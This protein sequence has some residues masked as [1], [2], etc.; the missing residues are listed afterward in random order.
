ML[1]TDVTAPAEAVLL[2]LL[3]LCRWLLQA[4]LAQR[5]A[6]QLTA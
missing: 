3:L 4:A 6:M 5:L 2:L 1:A